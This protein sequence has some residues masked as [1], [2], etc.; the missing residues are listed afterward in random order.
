[1]MTKQK[2]RESF[3]ITDYGRYCEDR[4]NGELKDLRL[5][6]ESVDA[7]MLKH[8]QGRIAAIR[9]VLDLLNLKV[10]PEFVAG[11]TGSSEEYPA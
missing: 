8:L 3:P 2:F 9:S 5:Q 1:M 4:L 7:D 6:L 11:A 10:K